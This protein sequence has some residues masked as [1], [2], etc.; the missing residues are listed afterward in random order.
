[1]EDTKEQLLEKFKA[2]MKQEFA[3]IPRNLSVA[4]YRDRAERCLYL[5]N[6]ATSNDDPI[7]A[8]EFELL[9]QKYK[10]LAFEKEHPELAKKE[11]PGAP[12][13]SIIDEIP[14]EQ[15]EK[16]SA[17]KRFL[18]FFNKKE[19]KVEIKEN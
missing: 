1:M 4:E 16:K 8:K 12:A 13:Q 15:P 7:R 19:V 10:Q 17:W 2:K 18:G 9:S 5:A 11:K 3:K 14:T 6:N